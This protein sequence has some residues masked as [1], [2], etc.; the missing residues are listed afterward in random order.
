MKQNKLAVPTENIEADSLV[1][2]TLSHIP[3]SLLADF[4][5]KIVKPYYS[6]SLSKAAKDLMQKAVAE[7]E[8]VLKHTKKVSLI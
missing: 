3:S 5:E 2:L 4:L 7:Q 6:G 1:D 8:F